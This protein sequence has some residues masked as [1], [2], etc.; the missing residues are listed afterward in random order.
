MPWPGARRRPPL[1][2]SAPRRSPHPYPSA[3]AP[4][5]CRSRSQACRN[6]CS[7]RWTSHGAGPGAGQEARR[8]GPGSRSGQDPCRLGGPPRSDVHGPQGDRSGLV[9]EMEKVLLTADIGVRTSQKLLEDMSGCWAN[10]SWATPRPS[11]RSCASAA[12][13]SSAWRR[14]RRA[15]F[16]SATARMF[17]ARNCPPIPAT[18]P[19][20]AWPSRR[21]W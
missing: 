8:H 4:R 15:S 5:S 13:T 10:K 20:R 18:A 12:G 2:R 3:P 14:R 17:N 9:E 11:G 6:R 16:A 1:A 7:C 19:I 21:Y